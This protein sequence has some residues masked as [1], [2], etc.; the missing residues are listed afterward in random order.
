M[1]ENVYQAKLIKKLYKMFPGCEILKND[2]GYRQGILD[3][4]IFYG[5]RWAMLEPKR[6]KTASFR[7]NQEYF[8][9]KLNE[10]SF[11]S[12]IY[13]E[14]EKEVLTALQKALSPR[15]AAHYKL[16]L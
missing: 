12:A 10:M 3:L 6:S 13:P 8:I 9:K 15:R 7:P 11:A 4:T 2:S 5:K 14:N 16:A 1:T